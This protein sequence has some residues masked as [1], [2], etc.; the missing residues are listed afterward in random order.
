MSPEQQARVDQLTAEEIHAIDEALLA[1][2]SHQF[3][4]IARVVGTAMD[5]PH[6]K[7]GIPDLFYALRIQHLVASG[8]LE[9]QGDT[10]AM[11]FSEIRLV[12]R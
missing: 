4:K 12:E 5:A 2:C 8:H 3:R 11:R 6:H 9:S 7:K 1:N 10:N